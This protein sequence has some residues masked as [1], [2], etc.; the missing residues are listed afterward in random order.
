MSKVEV[1]CPN[2]RRVTVR[3]T[4]NT[5]VLQVCPSTR[6]RIIRLGLSGRKCKNKCHG[7]FY[8]NKLSNIGL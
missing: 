6:R 7:S 5:K 2:G 1:L 8:N 4:P 3:T